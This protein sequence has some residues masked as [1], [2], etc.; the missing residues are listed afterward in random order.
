VGK[1]YDL[2]LVK[3][4]TVAILVGVHDSTVVHKPVTPPGVAGFFMPEIFNYIQ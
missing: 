1:S 3:A 4:L 2:G